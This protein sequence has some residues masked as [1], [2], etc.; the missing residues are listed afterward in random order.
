MEW[1][2]PVGW[3]FPVA[4]R[5]V[6][7][8]YAIK[9]DTELGRSNTGARKRRALSDV[10]ALGSQTP[11]DG[12]RTEEDRDPVWS[13]GTLL[14][15]IGM[16]SQQRIRFLEADPEYSLQIPIDQPCVRDIWAQMK[17]YNTNDHGNRNHGHGAPQ[18]HAWAAL[19]MA[20]CT[21]TFKPEDQHIIV[22][23]REHYI[24]I[25]QNRDMAAAYLSRCQLKDGLYELVQKGSQE[26]E[27]VQ[28]EFAE[29]SGH[30][31]SQKSWQLSEGHADHVL[32]CHDLPRTG[33]SGAT[34]ETGSGRA[35]QSLR[36]EEKVMSSEGSS[37]QGGVPG[38]WVRKALLCNQPGTRPSLGH[39]QHL[40]DNKS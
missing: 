26:G 35:G 31:G 39:A 30:P 22:M 10:D 25:S 38:P 23:L 28:H 27:E 24:T 11:K 2:A 7:Q 17:L 4:P 21:L 37:A 20:V 33:S 16:N 9:S 6:G 40:P 12:A 34:G 36:E 19:L 8:G 1:E 32:Q 3:T 29:A 15:K 14:L 5:Q 13:A 18:V